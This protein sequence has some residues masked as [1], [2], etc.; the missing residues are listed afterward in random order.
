MAKCFQFT[1]ITNNNITILLLVH[2]LTLLQVGVKCENY[3]IVPPLSSPL[4]G[5]EYA[6]YQKSIICNSKF[7]PITPNSLLD[8]QLIVQQASRKNITLKPLGHLHSITDII[9][10]SGLPINM[11]KINHFSYDTVTKL[12]RIGGGAKMHQ[13]TNNLH[14]FGR[15]LEGMPAYG[16]IT[17][18]GAIA[19]GAHGSS[20][21]RRTTLS[22]QIVGLTVVDGCGN[23]VYLSEENHDDYEA[24][25]AFRVNLGLLG[26]VYDVTIRTVPQYKVY[27]KNIAIEDFSLMENSEKIVKEVKNSDFFQFFWFPT[28]EQVVLSKSKVVSVNTS[29]N[30]ET[31]FIPEVSRGEASF[32]KGY[33]EFMQDFKLDFGLYL[34]QWFSLKSLVTSVL[35]KTPLFTYA[36]ANY[37]EG[38]KREFCCPSIGYSHKMLANLCKECFW[39]EGGSISSISFEEWEVVIPVNELGS[40]IQTMK[41]ILKS[42]P[43]EFYFTGILFRFLKSS[44]GLLAID[45]GR[46]SVGIEWALAGNKWTRPV[47]Q[48]LV[49]ALVLKHKGR[50]HWGKNGPHFSTPEMIAFQH[51]KYQELFA[52]QMERFDPNGVFINDFGQ[53]IRFV[54][55][56]LTESRFVKA[57]EK[58][59]LRNSSYVCKSDKDCGDEGAFCSNLGGF[60][61]CIT[62]ENG[63]VKLLNLINR[64]AIFGLKVVSKQAEYM[65][66]IVFSTPAVAASTIYQESNNCQ[67]SVQLVVSHLND[68]LKTR[69]SSATTINF[70]DR[71]KVVKHI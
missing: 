58:C 23:V 3:K 19:T 10:T 45:R 16:D 20:L 56:S 22:S 44:S 71:R 67:P 64:L 43:V 41:C 34:L 48:A 31:H 8:L 21:L 39:E 32:F 50:T 60:N 59:V 49:Q 33:I 5:Y 38:N 7:S 47:T 57:N 11:E 25:S 17:V 29:G 12:A 40:A 51:G 61:V 69:N 37:D 52:K 42:H 24:M 66:I 28:A 35:G 53:R 27:T 54:K 13:L 6:S 18:G 36:N 62:E 2:I 1:K 15:A 55:S 65:T 63:F 70:E 14:H 26:I 4:S 9:C 46:E 68:S 30:C